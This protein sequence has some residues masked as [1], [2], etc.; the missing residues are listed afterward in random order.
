MHGLAIAAPTVE[1]FGPG[2]VN[3]ESLGGTQF[4]C[5]LAASTIT[6]GNGN[7]ATFSVDLLPPGEQALFRHW[8]LSDSDDCTVTVMGSRDSPESSRLSA[9]T[10]VHWTRLSMPL[11]DAAAAAMAPSPST[12]TSGPTIPSAR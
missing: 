6:Q 12:D 2:T 1:T 3:C 8:C 9:V 5:L 4:D 7:V 11:N 10:S